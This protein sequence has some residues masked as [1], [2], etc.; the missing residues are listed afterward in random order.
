MLNQLTYQDGLNNA[1]V[2]DLECAFHFAA[3][4]I[5]FVGGRIG[6]QKRTADYIH[7][8]GL[9]EFTI[10]VVRRPEFTS[11]EWHVN[12]RSSKEGHTPGGTAL[13]RLL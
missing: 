1:G 10:F 2:V 3:H 12:S 5:H 7:V 13:C 6:A 9:P 11:L 4:P 8:F